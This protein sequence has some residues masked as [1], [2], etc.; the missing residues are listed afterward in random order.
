MARPWPPPCSVLCISPAAAAELSWVASARS[1]RP[2]GLSRP[3]GSRTRRPWQR[4][5]RSRRRRG[6]RC[7]QTSPWGAAP[8][9]QRRGS[10]RGGP[11]DGFL[12]DAGV[13]GDGAVGA[14]DVEGP[15][16]GSMSGARGSGASRPCARRGGTVGSRRRGAPRRR[17][18]WGRTP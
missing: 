15:P 6:S 4:Q 1:R 9:R 10:G 17:R 5:W 16:S 12:P 2:L 3:A 14:G 11:R 18:L 8:W 13:D 7:G